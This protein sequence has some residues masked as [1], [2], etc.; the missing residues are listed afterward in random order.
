M[1]FVWLT[2]AAHSKPSIMLCSL[3]GKR[4]V[5]NGDRSMRPPDSHSRQRG[6][7]TNTLLLKMG[8][9]WCTP[10][11]QAAHQILQVTGM[12]CSLLSMPT[13]KQRLSCIILMPTRSLLPP[14]MPDEYS[15]HDFIPRKQALFVLPGP[16]IPHGTGLAQRQLYA[17]ICHAPCGHRHSRCLCIGSTH[18]HPAP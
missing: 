2:L 15:R 11:K 13:D 9:K 10:C 7:C 1:H 4:W 6:Y 18:A 14:N 8:S 5:I 17:H 16:V 3:K 12:P